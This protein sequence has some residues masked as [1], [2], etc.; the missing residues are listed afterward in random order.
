MPRKAEKTKQMII[1]KAA[2]VFNEK[3]LLG[4]SIDDVLEITK[5]S[6]GCLYGHFTDRE[7]L[8]HAIAEHLLSRIVSLARNSMDKETTAKGKLLA[9]MSMYRNPLKTP[10]AGGCPIFNL[11]VDTDDTNPAIKQQ[12]KATMKGAIRDLTS[13]IRLGIRQKEFSSDIDPEEFALKLFLLIEGALVACRA[14]ESNKP[15]V[16][17]L[18]ILRRELESYQL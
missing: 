10:I 7:E 12:V 14:L 16:T 3:G 1:E 11:A 13:V 9:F 8:S 4:A 5:V 6:K 18:N 15:M 2:P 17:T